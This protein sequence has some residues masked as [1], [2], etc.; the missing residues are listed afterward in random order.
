MGAT[1]F[2]D[3]PTTKAN[4]SEIENT[5]KRGNN[6]DSKSHNYLIYEPNINFKI[7]F[8]ISMD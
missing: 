3:S 5:W 4:M 6:C 7:N 1:K 2:V 8:S